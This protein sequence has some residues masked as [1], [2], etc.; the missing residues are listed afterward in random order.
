MGD[1][2]RDPS[3][4]EILASIKRVISDEA[5]PPPP[6]RSR[7]RNSVPE[8]EDVLEL[9][10]QLDGGSESLISQDV[11]TASRGKLAALA[12]LRRAD[13]GAAANDGP[14]EKVVREMLKPMLRDWL[15]RHLP[16][17]VEELVQREI[18]RINADKD[19]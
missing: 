6:V 5:P 1:I 11:A 12:E 19:I 2:N 7:V 15:D 18:Q 9:S 16:E 13:G 14:L 8:E 17:I 10:D 4:E 3:M